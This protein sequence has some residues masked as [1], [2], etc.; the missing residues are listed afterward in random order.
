MEADALWVALIPNKETHMGDHLHICSECDGEWPCDDAT[1]DTDDNG[2]AF[3]VCRDCK[4]S[5][6]QADAYR[7]CRRENEAI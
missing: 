6:H 5:N 3:F 4:R 7:T 1:C 2:H